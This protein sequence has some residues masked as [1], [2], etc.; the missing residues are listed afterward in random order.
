M[1]AMMVDRVAEMMTMEMMTMITLLV[2]AVAANIT[3]IGAMFMMLLGNCVMA[4]TQHEG[5]DAKPR[6][7]KSVSTKHHT[8]RH[9]STR[10][11]RLRNNGSKDKRD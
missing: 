8:G 5:E 10:R 1:T 9:M 2:L 6:Q 11:L 7:A 4:A 3:V